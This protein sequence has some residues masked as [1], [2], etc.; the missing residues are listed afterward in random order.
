M[1]ALGSLL[2]NGA[3]ASLR[4]AD[5][6]NDSTGRLG[7]LV[8]PLWQTSAGLA[9]T[10]NLA[11]LGLGLVL[12]CRARFEP[13]HAWMSYE[14]SELFIVAALVGACSLLFVARAG[15]SANDSSSTFGNQQA[16]FLLG[17]LAI[18]AIT[19]RLG[20]ELSAVVLVAEM[21]IPLTLVSF[22]YLANNGAARR[23]GVLAAEVL[24]TVLL[25]VGF[26]AALGLVR[27]ADTMQ[28]HT[29]LMVFFA[30]SAVCLGLT[31]RTTSRTTPAVLSAL[32][33]CAAT[34]QLLLVIG[35][36]Q[37][38]IVFA[39]T[40]IGMICLTA[41]YFTRPDTETLS[42]F[43]QVSQWTGRLCV[44]YSSAATLLIA[45]ARLLTGETDWSLLN[46]VV[47]QVAAGCAAGLLSKESVWRRHF[48]VLATAQVF[49]TLLVVNSLSTLTLWQRGEVLLAVAGLIL[50]VT[51]FW[52][53]YREGDH[54]EDWVSFNLAAGSLLGAAPLTF[55]MLVQRFDN[56]LAEWGWVL[57]HEAGVL[58]IGLLLLGTGV[59]CRIRWSTVIGGL[60]LMVYVVSLVG[61]IRLPEQLQSTAIYMMIG[62]GLFFG[63]AVLLSIYRD[64]LLAIPKRMQ[65]GEGVFRVLKWR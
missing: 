29:G 7:E 34:W 55:G 42:Q 62:G 51:G 27:H 45:L 31:S 33:I 56:Q 14:F 13:V 5:S 2:A 25:A 26:G 32:S 53:W 39:A 46:L 24:A 9:N 21:L 43:F 54:K 10:L 40:F 3:R 58:V 52:G 6:E 22:A 11:T 1:T 15:T 64:R 41:S 44:S 35:V 17:W 59:L 38:A 47:V 37:F 63:T 48:W 36:T 8:E 23:R 19:V 16:Q 18:D 65:E 20:L 49:M 50:L 57:V 60:T 30:T 28:S 4:P 12:Y 61:L